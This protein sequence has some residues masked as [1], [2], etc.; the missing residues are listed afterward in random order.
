M[1]GVLGYYGKDPAVL[2]QARLIAEQYLADPASVDANL[3][4]T[5]LAIAARKRRRRALPTS[6]RRVFET[7]ANPEI[8][9][10]AL[11]LLPQFTDPAL[12]QR[13]MDYAA[14]GKVRN[15]DTASLFGIALQIGDNRELAWKYIQSHWVPGAGRR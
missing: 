10:G 7:S 3:G 11:H 8:Q 2:D 12:L 13:S 1:F 5:A 15:Q 4:Q 6:C 14:S 9:E